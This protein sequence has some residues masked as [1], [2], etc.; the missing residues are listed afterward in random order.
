M[1][2][3]QLLT[4]LYVSFF[5][6]YGCSFQEGSNS[7]LRKWYYENGNLKKVQEYSADSVENGTYLFY[8]EQGILIDSAQIKNGKF[9]GKRY[10]FRS[11][12]SV[13]RIITYKN[14]VYRDETSY[15]LNG[16]KN[17]YGGYN[18]AKD[19]T[20]LVQFD[21]LGRIKDYQGDPIY[22]WVMEENYGV[23]DTVSIELLAPNIPGF[24]TKVIIEY[25]VGGA[26]EPES[27]KEA[28]PDEFNRVVYRKKR[29]NPD[30]LRIFNFVEISDENNEVIMTDTL[31]LEISETGEASYY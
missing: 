8:N 13:H 21:S 4:I 3:N 19:L 17:K 29:T 11:N 7:F 18:Y 10:L 16:N 1:K 5:G 25:F 28:S 15:K 26:V 20:F 22:S 6:L 2:I 14:N 24:K 12:S 30:K 23:G 31:T 9:H 27:R